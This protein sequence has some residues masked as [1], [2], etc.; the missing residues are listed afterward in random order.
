MKKKR[1]PKKKKEQQQMGQNAPENCQSWT[2]SLK[3]KGREKKEQHW[4]RSIPAVS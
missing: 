1:R 2:K 3:K 4:K